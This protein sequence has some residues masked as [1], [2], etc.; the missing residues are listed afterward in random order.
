MENLGLQE[1][2]FA[3]NIVQMYLV[4]MLILE[5]YFCT[6]K[7]WHLLLWGLHLNNQKCIESQL[8]FALRLLVKN[9][10]TNTCHKL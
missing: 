9:K 6:V 1:N 4:A 8:K 5:K 10:G 7:Y 3:I 2:V